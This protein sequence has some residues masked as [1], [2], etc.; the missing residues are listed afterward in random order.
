VGFLALI[1]AP[2]K[3]DAIAQRI[4]TFRAVD[5]EELVGERGMIMGVHRTADEWLAHPQGKY[6]KTVPL[7]EIV[8]IGDSAP[9]PWTPKPAQLLSGIKVLS[10]THV[11]ASTTV[12]S[13]LAGFGAQVLELANAL[14]RND[15]LLPILRGLFGHVL[16]R[17]R[18]AELLQWI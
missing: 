11:I 4:K 7:I 9:V 8:K 14:R 15:A 17:G 10:C 2:P 16:N 6:L 13:T 18:V 1:G 3:R 5:L 12:S